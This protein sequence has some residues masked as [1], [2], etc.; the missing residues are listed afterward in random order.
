MPRSSC[1]ASGGDYEDA[2]LNGRL[3]GLQSPTVAIA[4]IHHGLVNCSC[5]PYI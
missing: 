2:R 5:V 3:S 4:A 1:L